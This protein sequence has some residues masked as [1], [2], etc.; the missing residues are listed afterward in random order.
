[1]QVLCT[2]CGFVTLL[3]GTMWSECEIEIVN[4]EVNR[5]QDFSE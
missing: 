3:Q 4:I 5:E 1:V 2:K